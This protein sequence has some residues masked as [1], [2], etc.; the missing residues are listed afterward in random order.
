MLNEVGVFLRN[1]VTIGVYAMGSGH[2]LGRLSILIVY[3][4]LNCIYFPTSTTPILYI[5][6]NQVKINEEKIM[7]VVVILHITCSNLFRY[8]ILIQHKWA[9]MPLYI[10]RPI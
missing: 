2:G 6:L 10:V 4:L 5:M 3:P 1:F 8:H 9:Q 7:V